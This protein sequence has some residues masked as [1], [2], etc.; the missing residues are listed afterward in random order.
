MIRSN[1]NS[2]NGTNIGLVLI[3]GG[4]FGGPEK[5]CVRIANWLNSHSIF[6]VHIYT[7]QRLIDWLKEKELL[8]NKE[9]NVKTYDK[10]VG[11]TSKLV[12]KDVVFLT[13]KTSIDIAEKISYL[14][15][16]YDRTLKLGL[17]ARNRIKKQYT[18]DNYG[19]YVRSIYNN[20]LS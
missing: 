10:D 6:S 1:T 12:D 2:K 5:R 14:I 9:I 11:E 16:D 8:F 13:K 3:N 4:R 18:V 19:S 15:K 17:N 20:I 7:S